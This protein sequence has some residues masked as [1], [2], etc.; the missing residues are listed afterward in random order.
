MSCSS[1]SS[2]RA[3]ATRRAGPVLRARITEFL[4]FVEEHGDGWKVLFREVGV[5]AARSPS[6]SPQLREQIAADDPPG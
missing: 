5:D 1:G 2:Q 4:A 3:R 6:R